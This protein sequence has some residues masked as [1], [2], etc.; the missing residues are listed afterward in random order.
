MIPCALGSLARARKYRLGALPST[1][2]ARRQMNGRTQ[3][4]GD[5]W[6]L[7]LSWVGVAWKARGR[8]R[9]LRLG[10]PFPGGD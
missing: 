8:G 5:P 4:G 3:K 10:K 7:K 9:D 1:S 6:Y 2:G